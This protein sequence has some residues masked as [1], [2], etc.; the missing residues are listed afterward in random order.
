MNK[1]SKYISGNE[2]CLRELLGGDTKMI[3]PDLQRDYCWGDRAYANPNDKNPRELVSDFVKNIVELFE[4]D[5]SKRVT[6]GLIYGYEQPHN[7]IQICDGQQRLTTLFLLLGYINKCTRGIFQE[8]IIS[9][10]E[11][12]SWAERRIRW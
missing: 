6:L 10:K 12:K 1:D 8:Y 5:E 11:M 9:N 2:Y 3:I 7:H 4:A